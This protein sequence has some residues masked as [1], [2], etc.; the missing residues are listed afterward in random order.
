MADFE[1]AARDEGFRARSSRDM[2]RKRQREGGKAGSR[3]M[4]T[5]VTEDLVS[6]LSDFRDTARSAAPAPYMQQVLTKRQSR[7][8]FENM[9]P[10]Q[11]VVLARQLGPMFYNFL[12]SIGLTQSTPE[13]E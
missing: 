9:D 5:N 10:Q 6:I 4:L 13:Q 11:R 12:D 2:A 7:R 1:I 3:H 8:R